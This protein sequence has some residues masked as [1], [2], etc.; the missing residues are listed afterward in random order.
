MRL[1][2]HLCIWIHLSVCKELCSGTQSHC[3][4]RTPLETWCASGATRP[5]RQP[6]PTA[7]RVIGFEGNQNESVWVLC[8]NVPVLVSAQNL[9]PAQDAEALAQ[10]VLQGEAILPE[11]LIQGQQQF[12]DLRDVPGEDIVEDTPVDEGEGPSYGLLDGPEPLSSIFEEEEEGEASAARGRSR[13]PPPVTTAR[14]R[15]VSTAEPEAEQTPKRRISRAELLDDLPASIRARFEERRVEEEANVSIREKFT[16][17]WSNRL[18]TQE[19][20]EQEL[21]ELPESLK[22]WNCT[23]SVRSHIDGSRAKEWKKYEDFQAAIPIKGA[24]AVKG[25][26]GCRPRTNTIEMG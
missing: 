14:S 19:Q 2:R 12:E 5:A 15:R 18:A 25:I 17:F 24:H 3:L 9:R 1:R 20:V 11:S 26:A 21:K 23:P 8:Q 10:A 6:G 7:S 4:T 22:Y 13:S 16:G